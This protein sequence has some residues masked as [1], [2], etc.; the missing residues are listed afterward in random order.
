MVLCIGFLWVAF[1]KRSEDGFLSV[2]ENGAER[3]G[4]IGSFVR[5]WVVTLVRR[6]ASIVVWE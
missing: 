1:P 4:F 3:I 2:S 6:A 5:K